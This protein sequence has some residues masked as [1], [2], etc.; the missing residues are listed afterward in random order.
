MSVDR[1]ERKSVD[2]LE[3]MTVEKKSVEKQKVSG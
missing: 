3:R 1:V 2:R